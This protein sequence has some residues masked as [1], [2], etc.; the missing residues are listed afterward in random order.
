MEY[1]EKIEL[2]EA[3]KK[4]TK[5]F[6]IEIIKLSKS[7]P[8]SPEAYIVNRQLIRAATSV[9]SNYR[10][11]CRARSD[12]EFYSKICIVVEE[13]DESVFWLEIIMEADIL[14]NEQTQK[15]LAE[16]NEILSVVASS[17]RT[18]GKYKSLNQQI[19]KSIIP[20]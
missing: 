6:A 16:A 13:A 8:K 7:F 18:A 3:F 17:K 10:A 9:A 1:A 19:N 15:I 20:S 2:A 12:A 5:K 14:K 11:V 4:R